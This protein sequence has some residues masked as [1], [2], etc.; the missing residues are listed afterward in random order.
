MAINPPTDIVLDVARAADPA[1]YKAAAEKLALLGTS[2]PGAAAS[3]DSLFDS[4]DTAPSTAADPFIGDLRSRLPRA[5]FAASGK[6]PKAYQKFE[7]V[8]LQSFVQ[9]LLPK[10]ASSVYGS[11]LAGSY[12]SSMLAEQIANQIA[13][14]GGVGIAQEIEAKHPMGWPAPHATGASGAFSTLPGVVGALERHF[15]DGL[16]A[17]DQSATDASAT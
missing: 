4:M 9:E 11:G 13:E 1:R 3:F 5:E 8:V 7:A 17:D 15:V 2:A 6:P 12:W 10:D 16:Q 14:S